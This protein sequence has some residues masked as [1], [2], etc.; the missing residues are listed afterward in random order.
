MT[1]VALGAMVSV[2]SRLINVS[3][4]EET[5]SVSVSATSE[6]LEVAPETVEETPESVE[7][8]PESVEGS[9]LVSTVL[10]DL[11]QLSEDEVL[12]SLSH[13]TREDVKSWE[14]RYLLKEEIHLP[15][16]AGR[17]CCPPE[18]YQCVYQDALVAGLRLPLHPFIIA[19]MNFFQL[20]LGQ[21]VPNSWRLLV[22][23]LVLSLRLGI[24]PTV[25]LFNLFFQ[26][27]SHPGKNSWYY[28]R[29]REGK[30]LVSNPVTSI[31]HWKEKFVFV[32]V[33]G[34]MRSWNFEYVA[35]AVKLKAKRYAAEIAKLEAVGVVSASVEM[36]SNESLSTAG[37]FGHGSLLVID[38]CLFFVCFWN[39]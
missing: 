24:T 3:S 7:V 22:G 5:A 1:G 18:G 35:P 36:L 32:K 15:M 8:A 28:V 21:I 20:G 17:G 25:D 14:E 31:R 12:R 38:V 39:F 30:S 9:E 23:F 2:D 34:M 37:V 16:G 29:G 6:T 33:K 10:G 13:L 19:V 27:A 4:L 26:I 11:P